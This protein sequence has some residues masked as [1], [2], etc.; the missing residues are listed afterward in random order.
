MRSDPVTCDP[1][2]ERSAG[3]LEESWGQE[4]WGQVSHFPDCR[5]NGNWET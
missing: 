4:S 2:G 3:R 5:I 1:G